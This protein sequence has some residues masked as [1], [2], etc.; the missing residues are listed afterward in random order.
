[1]WLLASILGFIGIGGLV[2]GPQLIADPTGA[3]LGARVSWPEATPL[4]GWY[5]V[6]WVLIVFMG[7]V[8]ALIRPWIGHLPES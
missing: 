6:G 1:M 3:A 2:S 5:L 7:V 4:S 8:P